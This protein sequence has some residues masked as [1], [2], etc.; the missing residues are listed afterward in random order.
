MSLPRLF[1]GGVPGLKPA[2]L[3]EPGHHRTVDGCPTCEARARGENRV[4]PGL[5]VVDPP[6]GRPDRVY[7]T[8]DREYARHY[9]SMAWYGDLYVVE[10]IG[11][12]E[13]S[14]EDHFPTWCAPAARVLS[15]YSRAVQLTMAERRR[16]NRRW[17]VA[18]MIADQRRAAHAEE[19]AFVEGGPQ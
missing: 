17:R 12:V 18:D 13:P 9:A 4:V 6:T 10:L 15:V 3:I 7:A 11:N 8:S 5:G 2:D 14:E 19:A 16:L 1:H